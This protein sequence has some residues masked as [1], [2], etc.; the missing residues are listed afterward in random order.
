MQAD[1]QRLVQVLLNLLSNAIKYNRRGGH[2]R[3]TS[4]Q[5]DQL[6]PR[7]SPDRTRVA[8]A[9]SQYTGM[10]CKGCPQSLRTV[11]VDG[12]GADTMTAPPDCTFAD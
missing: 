5:A 1:R 12:S 6:Q 8:F 3:L 11:G 7:L 4:V 9:E 10:S 2:V